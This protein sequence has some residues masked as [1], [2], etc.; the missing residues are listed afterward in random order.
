[1]QF[2]ELST[3]A[4]FENALGGQAITCTGPLGTHSFTFPANLPS[5]ATANKTFLIGTTNLA[6][7]PGGV[8]PDYVFTN[9]VPFLFLNSGVTNTIGI[10]GSLAPSAAY[11]NLPTDGKSSLTGLG[12]GMIVV[13]TNSPKNFNNQSNTIVPVEFTAATVVTTNFVVTFRTATGVNGAAGPNYAIQTNASISTANWSTATNVA[14]NGTVKSVALPIV[15]GTN[16]F[17]RLRVP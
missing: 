4:G 8:T 16:R 7:A 10:T 12:S 6:L 17:F 11:T 14:G 15:P 3:S 1:V 9:S 13:P 5:T 2:V